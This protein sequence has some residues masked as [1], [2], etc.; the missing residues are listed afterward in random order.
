MWHQ[1][2]KYGVTGWQQVVVTSETTDPVTISP[3]V[4]T[5]WI[6]RAHVR[7]AALTLAWPSVMGWVSRSRVACHPGELSVG[8]GRVLHPGDEVPEPP[9]YGGLRRLKPGFRTSCA[10]QTLGVAGALS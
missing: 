10:M 7:R 5:P 2:V 4:T 9:A 6:P 8:C 3:V 1:Y